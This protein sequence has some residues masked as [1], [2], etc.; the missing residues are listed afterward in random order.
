MRKLTSNELVQVY[1]GGRKG[2]CG[3]GGGKGGSGSRGKG[4][5]S[6]RGSG[7][8][9]GRGSGSGSGRGSGSGKH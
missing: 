3:K 9:S 5:R 7:S 4:S 1:G 8:G 2:H 6:G